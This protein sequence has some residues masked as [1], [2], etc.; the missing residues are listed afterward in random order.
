[1]GGKKRN[2]FTFSIFDTKF[3][4]AYDPVT[5]TYTSDAANNSYIKTT[6]ASVNF[7]K[8]LKYSMTI[9]L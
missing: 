2:A 5:G 6:G 4:N 1:L 3:A 8:Q 9:F 7:A